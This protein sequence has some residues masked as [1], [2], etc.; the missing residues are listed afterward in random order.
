MPGLRFALIVSCAT[1]QLVLAHVGHW[2]HALL[3]LAPV[4]VISLAL[5]RSG[6]REDRELERTRREA[7]ADE[8]DRRAP[9]DDEPDDL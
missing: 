3:Y 2:Y 6:V 8:P 9:G 1:S 4:I 5:W 7:P